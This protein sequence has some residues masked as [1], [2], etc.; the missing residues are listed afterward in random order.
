[1]GG[2]DMR[3]EAR[4]VAFVLKYKTVCGPFTGLA[5]GRF[6]LVADFWCHMAN[7]YY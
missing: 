7:G 1:M 3:A 5:R 4:G 6:R 2:R